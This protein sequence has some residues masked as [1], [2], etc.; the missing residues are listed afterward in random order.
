M[1]SVSHHG[2]VPIV[3]AWNCTDM[4]VI[5][6]L[7]E[8]LV[9]VTMLENGYGVNLHV[10]V[11]GSQRPAKHPQ[12]PSFYVAVYKIKSWYLLTNYQHVIPV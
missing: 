11:T 5:R 7:K 10:E 8:V 4:D 3:V 12:V 9:R 6:S 2:Q 1:T